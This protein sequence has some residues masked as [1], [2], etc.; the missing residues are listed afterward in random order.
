MLD[1]LEVAVAIYDHEGELVHENRAFSQLT[2]ATE[3]LREVATDLARGVTQVVREI[4]V[5]PSS[6]EE[7]LASAEIRT[8][9]GSFSLK[10]SYV[11]VNRGKGAVT[12][13]TVVSV[14]NAIADRVSE[15]VLQRRFDLT[16]QEARVVGLLARGRSNKQVA[17]LLSISTH[18]ARH[19][20]ERV[21]KK[22]DVS[23]RSEVPALVLG[24]TEQAE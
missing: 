21:M 5:G 23:K 7:A 17:R 10:G 3:E 13:A 12:A 19:H 18:T 4:D 9:E 1:T 2:V 11:A 8:A 6:V 16:H 24:L 22:L 20:V 14:R 15:T